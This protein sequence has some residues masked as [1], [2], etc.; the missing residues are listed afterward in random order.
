[1]RMRLVVMGLTL[2]LAASGPPAATAQAPVMAPPL[3]PGEVLLEVNAVGLVT[4]RADRAT[5]TFTIT[6]SGESEAAARTA[7]QQSIAEIRAMLRGH[8]LTDADIRVQPINTYQIDS[9]EAA[10]ANAAMTMDAA[11]ADMNATVESMETNAAEDVAPVPAPSVS[12]NAQTEIVIRN[13]DRVAAIQS[14]LMER[15]IFSAAAVNYALNDDSGPRRQARTQAIQ[16]ARADAESYAAAL[17]M[18]VLRVVRVT[19][20]L[21]LE[22]LG[23]A[24]TE[25]QMVSL[26]FGPNAARA[27]G[28][29][30]PTVAVVGVDYALAPR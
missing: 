15:G 20:R 18:R 23:M 10:M 30:V 19:E 26:M 28:S 12:A 6:G 22:L 14:A 29:Q 1:M 25:N 24:A 17:N 27:Y 16:K 13:I 8:G 3:A 5:M 21:G 2:A 9:M 11:A 4:T 7:T